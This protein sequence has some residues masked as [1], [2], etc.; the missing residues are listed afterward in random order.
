MPL[1]EGKVTATSRTLF[2]RVNNQLRKQKAVRH[3]RWKYVQ[4]SN[5]DLLFDVVSDIGE[6][7][8]LSYEHPEVVVEIKRRLAAWEAELAQERPEYLVR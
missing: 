3:D 6:R 2:W 5:V 8:D 7:H 1:L 4:D